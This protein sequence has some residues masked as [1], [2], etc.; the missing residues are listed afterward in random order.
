MKK[1]L[2]LILIIFTQQLFA[3]NCLDLDEKEFLTDLIAQNPSRLIELG[4]SFDND[5]KQWKGIKFKNCSIIEIDLTDIYIKDIPNS[6]IYAKNLKVLKVKIGRKIS[7]NLFNLQY[8]ETLHINDFYDIEDV[9]PFFER[10]QSLKELKLNTHLSQFPNAIFKLKNL[11]YLD[12]A[13]NNIKDMPED[14]TRL[15]NLKHLDISDNE[16]LKGR[17]DDFYEFEDLNYLNI[18]NTKLS[19]NLI[20][21]SENL[22]Y[23]NASN[24]NLNYSTVNISK[25]SNLEIIKLKDSKLKELVGLKNQSAL[26]VIDFTNN[27]FN[28]NESFTFKNCKTLDSV[29]LS[30]NSL[31]AIP[32]F[33]NYPNY[34]N[35]SSN[36]IFDLTTEDFK[37]LSG[38]KSVDL[39][40][41]VM[42]RVSKDII[43]LKNCEVLSLESN[44]LETL[45]EEIAKL[46]TLLN[47]NLNNNNLKALPKVINQLQ[48]LSI[49][50]VQGNNLSEFLMES[51]NLKELNLIE[52]NFSKIPEAIYGNTNLEVFYINNFE[53]NKVPQEFLNF[54]NLRALYLPFEGYTDPVLCALEKRNVNIEQMYIECKN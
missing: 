44:K 48:S 39:S 36:P 30:K 43:Y 5:I 18:E 7:R 2:L 46:K 16:Y 50:N 4:W 22:N 47:L 41:L 27:L 52:N 29:N 8:L 12:L 23:L 10:L 14:I 51:S 32:E 9:F 25:S 15:K 38:V 28:T 45:P 6:I 42:E 3:N 11:E 13:H 26:K 40:F 31:I 53:L 24:V 17:L 35:L 54:K 20:T 21:N 33:G 34:V 1:N 37:K 19:G 49:L